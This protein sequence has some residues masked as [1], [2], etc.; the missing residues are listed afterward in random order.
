MALERTSVTFLLWQK[1]LTENSRGR[2]GSLWLYKWPFMVAETWLADVAG[3]TVSKVRK[4]RGFS[5]GVQL[6]V[7]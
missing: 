2:E 6:L 5:I 7:L 3:H 4:Q 1:C